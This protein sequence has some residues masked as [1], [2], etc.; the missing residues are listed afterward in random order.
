MFDLNH[1]DEFPAVDLYRKENL[2]H[3]LKPFA[4]S[5]RLSFRNG[6]NLAQVIFPLTVTSFC[7][8]WEKVSPPNVSAAIKFPCW[9]SLLTG[10]FSF[11]LHV[12]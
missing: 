6:L 4:A 5:N 12:S 7:R 1:S 8:C 10:K 9:N 3:N 11:H 2:D